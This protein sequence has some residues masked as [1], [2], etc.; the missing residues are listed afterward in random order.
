MAQVAMPFATASDASVRWLLLCTLLLAI[1]STIS[2]GVAGG[3]ALALQQRVCVS[4]A[5]RIESVVM[6]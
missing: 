4:P 1:F 5:Q 3:F 6:T 2:A